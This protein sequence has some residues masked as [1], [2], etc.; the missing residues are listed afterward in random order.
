MTTTTPAPL[1]KPTSRRAAKLADIAERSLWTL[2]E[3]ATGAGIVAGWNALDLGPD[4][5]AGWVA[6]ITFVLALIKTNLAAKFANGSASTLPD[7]LEPVP[8]DKVIAQETPSGLVVAGHGRVDDGTGED[9]PAGTPLEVVP[10]EDFGAEDEANLPDLGD[11]LVNVDLP[12]PEGFDDG[13]GTVRT[14]R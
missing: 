7:H 8:A 9:I 4:L 6:P 5:A 1:T 3:T 14:D 13:A 2:A 12:M 11:D 10:P